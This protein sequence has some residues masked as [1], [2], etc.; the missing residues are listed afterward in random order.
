MKRKSIIIG[1]II[2]LAVI[3]TFIAIAVSGNEKTEET[4]ADTTEATTTQEETETTVSREGMMHSN[5]TGEWVDNSIGMRRP[6]AVMLN[7]I[8]VAVPQSGISKASIVYEAPVEGGITRLLGVFENYDGLDKIGSVRSARTY[9][10]YLAM[11]FDA[12]YLHYGSAHYADS[13]LNSD[14]VSNL[15]GL[16]GIGS[17]VYYRTSDRP[18]PH[19]AYTSA[20]GITNGISALGYRTQTDSAYE[21]HF[22]FTGD[23]ESNS[24]EGGIPA[25]KISVGYRINNPWFEFNP[26]DGLYYRFQYGAPHT[27]QMDGSQLAYKNVL[28]Q[29]CNYSYYDGNGYLNIDV[30]GGGSGVFISNGK[31]VDITWNKEST[32]NRAR[33]FDSS[34]NEIILNQ[35][36]TWV[37]IVLNDAKDSVSIS[38]TTD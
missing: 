29:Y 17:T 21:S 13:L 37:C 5:L 14:A 2:V 10:V 4:T 3:V 20:T 30:N 16:S 12:I 22:V 11:E 33:Y 7:N 31:A 34:G 25:G 24:L 1:S 9:Y 38:E 32:S 26:A 19:N 6:A 28:I 35:G 27:D 18:A 36:K 8:K 23:G 15:S